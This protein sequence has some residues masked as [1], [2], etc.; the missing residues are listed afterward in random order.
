M[1]SFLVAGMV[2]R[3]NLANPEFAGKKNIETR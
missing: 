2:S 3:F 1:L